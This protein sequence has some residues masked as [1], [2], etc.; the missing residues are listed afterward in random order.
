M[1]SGPGLPFGL[2]DSGVPG[3]LGLRGCGWVF[4]VQR[5][6]YL[7]SHPHSGTRHYG[8]LFKAAVFREIRVH[9]PRRKTQATTLIVGTWVSSP[10][11]DWAGSSSSF[12]M[13]MDA[14][15]ET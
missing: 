10:C 3:K 1:F 14:S 12:S 9:G 5:R 11:G 2:H 6:W 8:T 4:F 15:L 7:T 13:V